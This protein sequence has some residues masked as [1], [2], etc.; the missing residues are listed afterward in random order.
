MQRQYNDVHRY[1][2]VKYGP[3]VGKRKFNEYLEKRNKPIPKKRTVAKIIKPIPKKRTVAKIRSTKETNEKNNDYMYN[4]IYK[5][6][7]HRRNVFIT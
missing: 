7:T 1:Y 3:D 2:V 5:K 6:R 4:I